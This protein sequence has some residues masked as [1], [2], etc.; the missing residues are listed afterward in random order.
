MKIIIVGCG[1][2]GAH[3]ALSLS[4]EGHSVTVV[5]TDREALSSL[6]PDFQGEIVVGK[7]IDED[8]LRRAGIEEADVFI[9]AT[10]YENTNIMASYVASEIFGVKNVI[11]RLDDP[12]KAEIFQSFGLNVISPVTLAAEAIRKCVEGIQCTLL[13]SA[14]EK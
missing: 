5:D 10:G 3:L 2:L 13:S 12:K 6:G 11:T 14:E 9:A 7:G 8:V 4:Q 1:R